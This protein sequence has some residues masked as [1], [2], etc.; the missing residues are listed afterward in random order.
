MRIESFKFNH[1]IREDIRKA[2]G[3]SPLNDTIRS[4]AFKTCDEV[5]ASVIKTSV[6]LKVGVAS[7]VHDYVAFFKWNKRR[8]FLLMDFAGGDGHKI[9]EV[10]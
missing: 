5:S 9:G 8:Y 7:V 6:P 1:L 3:I 10:A 4:I 2:L